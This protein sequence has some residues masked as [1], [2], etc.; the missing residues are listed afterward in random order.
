MIDLSG[1][2]G[3]SPFE[4]LIE[5]ARKVH[6]CVALVRPAAEAIVA[7]DLQRLDELQQ[8]IQRVHY[9]FKPTTNRSDLL[10]AALARGVLTLELEQAHSHPAYDRGS[11]R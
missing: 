4:P 7:G 3:R 8:H 1:I 10:R 9:P 5:H 2:F 6:E 11:E